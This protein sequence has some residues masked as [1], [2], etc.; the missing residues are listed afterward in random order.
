[1]IEVSVKVPEDRLGEFYELVGR[2]LAGEQVKAGSTARSTTTA[3]RK[4]KNSDD[5]LPSAR[6][7]WTQFSPPAKALFAQLFNNPERKFSGEQLADMLGIPNGKYGV[8]G[9]LAW[10]ARYCTAL[11][12]E[13][14]WQ[15]EE[16]PVGGSACYWAEREVADLFKKIMDLPVTNGCGHAEL[17]L[18]AKSIQHVV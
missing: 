1:M 11:N 14:P 7:V 3:R 12:Y 5:H 17:I 10:P 6:E 13:G 8:G 15:W 9:V 2:W 16:G 4:W 18:D